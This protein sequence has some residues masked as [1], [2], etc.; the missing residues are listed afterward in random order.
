[1][2]VLF[3]FRNAEW[4]G[5]EYLSAVLKKGGHQTELLFD[6]GTGD[7]EYK[8]SFLKTQKIIY[9]RFLQ[10]AKQ[11]KPDLFCFSMLTNLFP[12]CKQTMQFLKSYFPD[13]PI[14][15]GGLHPT[16][17]PELVLNTKE[18]D[19][20]CIGEG[21][22]ALLELCNSIEN[23]SQRKDIMNIWFKEDGKIIK[24]PLRP[25]RQNLDELPFPDKDIFYRYGCFRDRIYVMTG[26]GCPY[27]CSY[28]FNHS[29][30]QLYKN[31][32]RYV[33]QRSVDNCINELIYYKSKYKIREVFFYD[34]TFTLNQEW[35]KQFCDEYRKN[36]KLPFALNIR[37]NTIN[38]EIVKVLK[39]A[40]C[41]Y[42]V[43]GV[44]SGDEYIRNQVMKR[45]LSEKV[46]LEA[47]KH[48]HSE[49]VKLCTLN[50][51][52]VPG[53]TPEQMWRTVEFNWKLRPNG[54]SM[55]STFYPFPKTELYD[56]A[57]KMGFLDKDGIE[58]VNNGDGNYRADTIL[59]HPF[60]K[61]IKKVTTFEPIMVRLPKVFHPIFKI[62]PPIL[63]LR[64]LA[65][66]FY[67]PFQHLDYRI[68]EFISMQYCSIYKKLPQ[69]NQ[70]DGL[71]Q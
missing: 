41:Y 54:G 10:I 11:F 67:A 55:A 66:L 36:I 57:M 46:M 21:E 63:P 18:V 45:N 64:L 44:E 48:I 6:P 60:K 42:V 5:I 69:I 58:K 2:K 29:Y 38:K 31:S 8:L 43:M 56:L 68:K 9:K 7:I 61:T 17:F 53:E 15:A 51:I 71:D 35:V 40:G 13:V 70:I 20:I 25:L 16:M 49:G 22:D 27:N 14:I 28:C 23:G 12:W 37:A 24:N 39:N 3:V 4:L 19:M 34:D 26:R 1:M 47:A 59:D 33:R 30:K 50:V 52:G 62:L 65:I 32:G